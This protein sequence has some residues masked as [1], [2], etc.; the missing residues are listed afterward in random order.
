ME[1]DQKSQDL[2][3]SY[4]AVADE[5]ARRIYD[6]LNGKPLDRAL[7]ERFVR[8]THG[9]LCDVGTGPG[10]VARYLHDHGADAFGIDLSAGMV[11][12]ARRLNPGMD[13]R[14]GNMLSLD[15]KEGSLG[16]ITAFYSVIHVPRDQV[17]EALREFKRVLCPGGLVLIAFHIGNETV[18][19]NDWWDKKVSLDFAFFTSDE[20]VG[21]LKTAGLEVV[22]VIE[23]DPYPEVEHQS[24]RSYI[25]AR[26][27]TS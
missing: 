8:E 22:E 6:E 20:M 11:E 19:R 25:F 9:Q 2:Q 1:N 24:Q 21:Y 18:H 14:Q 15:L 12:Q 4:D 13:F 7:L 3:A 5:Y 26:K 17:V 10:H 27:A 23:R 16:G